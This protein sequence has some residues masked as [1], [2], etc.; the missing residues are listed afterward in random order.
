M[1][2]NFL[3]L[4]G[5]SVLALT[6]C[7]PSVNPFYTEKDLTFD[8]RLV[9]QWQAEPN[10]VWK[11]EA[12]GENNYKLTVAEKDNKE[13]EFRARLFKIEDA[14]Y[15]DVIPTKCNFSNKQA[16]MV[17]SAM[18]S[19]HLLMS[20]AQF[21]PDL[22]IAFCDYDWLQKFLKNTPSAL[23]HRVEGDSLLITASTSDLQKFVANHATELFQEA[24]LFAP[25]NLIASPL[26]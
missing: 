20:V 17:S 26:K 8:D 6:A 15:L 1:K 25:T 12:D 5:V 24:K 13:G 22:K 4:L 23:A 9:G 14:H 3:F 21:Q 19:G 2:R 7:I 16:D 11:F 18:F 10:E